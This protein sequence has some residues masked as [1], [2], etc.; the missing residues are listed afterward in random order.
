MKKVF[1]YFMAFLCV[2]LV[3]CS[4]PDTQDVYFVHALGFDE[5]DEAMRFSFLME[6]YTKETDKSD[7]NYFV[8]SISS[9]TTK[10]ALKKLSHSHGTLY[11][12]QDFLYLLSD[13]LSRENFCDIAVFITKSPHL[14]SKGK[15][16]CVSSVSCESLLSVSN[17]KEAFD[18]ISHLV[19]DSKVNLFDFFA[20]NLDGKIEISISHISYFGKVQKA[21]DAIYK[22]CT[23]KTLKEQNV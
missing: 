16:V 3:S 13:S 18:N 19:N 4:N 8:E 7:K 9:K 15:P 14:S 2:S 6:K 22:N 17:T 5:K 20:K 21:K 1:L 23:V 12:G 11:F 10:D